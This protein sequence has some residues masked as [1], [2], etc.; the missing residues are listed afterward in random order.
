MVGDVGVNK[1]AL[2]IRA[3]QSSNDSL[4]I[5]HSHLRHRRR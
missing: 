1:K 3:A 5:V 2:G 4:V